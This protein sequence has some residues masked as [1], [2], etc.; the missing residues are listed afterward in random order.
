MSF[1]CSVDQN[2]CDRLRRDPFGP[3]CAQLLDRHF[4]EPL[5]EFEID[6][7][8]RATAHAIEH[9]TRGADLR[10]RDAF[11]AARGTRAASA[12]YSKG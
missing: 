1:P 8:R 5:R 6:R 11:A 4:V 12:A 3:E 10:P 7:D 2:R 9:V